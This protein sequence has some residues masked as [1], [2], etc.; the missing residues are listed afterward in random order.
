M[1]EFWV[2]GVLP[3]TGIVLGLFIWVCQIALIVSLASLGCHVCYGWPSLTRWAFNF[4]FIGV[5]TLVLATKLAGNSWMVSV[6]RLPHYCAALAGVAVLGGVFVRV[7][8]HQTIAFLPTGIIGPL[9]LLAILTWWLR[10][11]SEPDS[12]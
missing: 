6:T 3:F 10:T 2:R 11:R 9:A 8:R 1:S 5:P 12:D 7:E 4:I